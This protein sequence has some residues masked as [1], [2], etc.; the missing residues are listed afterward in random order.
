MGGNRYA[1]CNDAYYRGEVMTNTTIA[2]LEERIQN[3]IDMHEENRDKIKA[4]ET[5]VN[6]YDKLAAKWG[7]VCMFAAALGT[8]IMAFG[9]K[10]IGLFV[11]LS[12]MM[13]SK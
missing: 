1:R 4:L 5:R 10:V 6:D 8:S 9:D 3:L 12:L 11:K 7:G 2:V 13:S